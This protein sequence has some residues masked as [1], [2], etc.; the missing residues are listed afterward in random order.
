MWTFFTVHDYILINIRFDNT[1]QKWEN[2]AISFPEINSWLP[3]FP[4]KNTCDFR[5]V[6]RKLWNI[7]KYKMKA[8][9]RGQTFYSTTSRTGYTNQLAV[10]IK[11]YNQG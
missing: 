6:S 8:K 11:M 5:L 9:I 3:Y 1:T 4:A 10:F 2:K 7:L